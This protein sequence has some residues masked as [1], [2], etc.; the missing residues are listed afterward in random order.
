MAE[1]VQHCRGCDL[2]R[3]ATQAVFGEGSATAKC[4]MIGEQPGDQEDRQGHPFVGPS[5]QLLD[6][7]LADAG[8]ARKDV[9]ITNAVKHFKHE[10]VGKRRLHKSPNKSQILACRP[11]LLEELKIIKPR[12]LVCLGV[13]AANSIF[14]RKVTL[15][16]IRG[17][18][19][20]TSFSARTFVTTHPS[21]VL[22]SPDEAGR[23]EN[24]AA[25]VADLKQVA[26]ELEK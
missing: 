1:A 17:R 6:R 25:F 2:Y 15:R 14:D 18:F 23:R 10:I 9:Y 19:V 22:R 21:D 13:S 4:M 11:W 8:I 3:D 20:E 24:Y 16:D 12:V 26:A 7:A 5:G